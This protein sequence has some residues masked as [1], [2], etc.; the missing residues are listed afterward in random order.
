MFGFS[1]IVSFPQVLF[2]N[3]LQSIVSVTQEKFSGRGKVLPSSPSI[4]VD[5]I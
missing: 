4:N 3:H 2:I 5:T 1:W